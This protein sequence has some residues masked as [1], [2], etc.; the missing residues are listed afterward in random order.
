MPIVSTRAV[1]LQTFRYSDTSK[2][3]R[4]LTRDH[5]PLSVIARGA[6]RPRSRMSGLLEPFAEGQITLYLKR[7]R[8]LHALSGFD[9]LRERQTLG[10]DL[11]RFAGA[12]LLCEL[13][14]RV[15]PAE[16]DRAM[17]ELLVASL[18]RLVEC[19]RER[20]AASYIASAWQLVEAL[21]FAPSLDACVQCGRSLPEG[22]TARLDVGD[23]GVRCSDCTTLGRAVEWDDL[24]VLRSLVRGN[25]PPGT[26]HVQ[27]ALLADFI[28]YHAAEG[29]RIRSLEFL[30]VAGP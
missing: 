22:R 13:V 1:V 28:R 6:L 9:L 18:D 3:L 29:S 7:N 27:V 21:G 30:G 23:G 19:P 17:Y 5:G 24:V 15:A 10:R 16:P 11:S 2:I 14:M 26:S 12:S 25:A 4:L 20:V 8:D